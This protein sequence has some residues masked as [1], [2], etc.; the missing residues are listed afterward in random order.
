MSVPEFIDPH[1][2]A[3]YDSVNS[4]EPGTQPD[5]YLGVAQEIGAEAV[6]DVGCGTGI[7][8]LELASRGYRMIG[9]DPSPVM[10]EVARRK[11]G[12]DGVKWVRGDARQLGTPGADLAIMSGHVVQFILHD[13]DWLDAL[14]GVKE[15]LR[16]GGY[17]AFESR[18]PRAREWEHWT[19][20][21]RII[22]DSPGGRIE[23]WTE[24]TH[25]EDDVVHAVG[26]R[27][28]LDSNEELVSPFALRFR[29][30]ELLTQ[31]LTASGFSV[32]SV[33]GDW[34]RRPSGPSERELILIARSP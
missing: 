6:I 30:E 14:A 23:S 10:L 13:A 21:K 9:V 3:I 31:S 20:R 33:F 1:Q 32:V 16:P 2:V 4:Y 34:D 25:V 26:H 8:T 29:S 24:V 5:F 19:G 7:V 12:A 18:D 11:P 28:L 15:A 27:R 17:L 22:P